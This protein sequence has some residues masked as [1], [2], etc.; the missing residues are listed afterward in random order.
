MNLYL[1][2]LN[3]LSDSQV[4]KIFLLFVFEVVS[5]K[6]S[7]IKVARY[8]EFGKQ[9][10]TIPNHYELDKGTLKSILNQA[11]KYISEN[12]LFKHFYH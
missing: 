4:I 7:H 10:I 3:V 8:T 12:D 9:G 11:S 1:P 6:G 2:K 5:Q